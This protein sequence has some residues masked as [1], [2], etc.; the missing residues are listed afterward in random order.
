MSFLLHDPALAAMDAYAERIAITEE[1]GTTH[2]YAQLKRR[3]LSWAAVLPGL[4]GSPRDN[5][6]I[7]VLAPVTTDAIS[8]VI[9]ALMLGYAYVPL[10]E[11]SPTSR[12]RYVVDS[13][14]LDV[15]VADRAYVERHRDLDM[16]SSVRHILL[17]DSL[18]ITREDLTAPSHSVLADD[19]AYVL[20]SS[21]STGTPKGIVL[22]HRNAR[23]F[24]DWMQKEFQL[25]PDDVVMSRAPFKFDLS[26]FD[27]FNTLSAG[28]R[29]VL[30]DWTRARDADS[31]HRDYVA[32]MRRE[33]ATM[34]YTTPSTFIALMN[35][36]GIGHSAPPLRTVMYAGEPFPSAQ[37]RRLQRALPSTRIANIYGPTETNIITYYWIDKIPDGDVPVPLGREVDD[38]EIVVVNEAG[39]SLCAP[40]EVGELWCRGGTVTL[41]YLGMPEKTAE[42]LVRSPFHRAPA[43]FWRTGDFGF[44]DEHGVLHY[45]GRRDHMVKVRGY[46]VELGEIEA[47][48]AGHDGVDESVVVAVPD[49]HNGTGSVLACFFAPLPGFSVGDADVMQFLRA[50]VPDYMVPRLVN[51]L[52]A[53]P[54]TSSG[55]VDRVHLA[56]RAAMTLS[57]TTTP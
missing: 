31:R 19:V 39:D 2:T 27:V 1:N 13:T 12:L 50:S 3:V 4:K 54:K 37:L 9:A 57:S 51:G 30:F 6:F 52:D 53:L 15:I 47:A 20:H 5:P 42:H 24:T 25:T 22:T 43:Y 29:L 55:K 48:L 26:V 46:R 49:T 7:G 56:E 21:G 23:T 28:A 45:R 40:G 10:D 34:I 35:R 11:Q 17:T 36:G 14:D 33:A 8:V 44:R 38:T 16:A 32:L 18:P 41:G